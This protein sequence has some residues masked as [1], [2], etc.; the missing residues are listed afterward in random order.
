MMSAFRDT[1]ASRW[2]SFV[3]LP[4]EGNN[5]PR[6]RLLAHPVQRWDGHGG[7]SVQRSRSYSGAVLAGAS[8]SRATQLLGVQRTCL[9]R[10]A[11]GPLEAVGLTPRRRA[12]LALR[13]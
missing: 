4:D 3:L 5:A 12:S 2:R 10:P 7:G 9:G 11:R 6:P 1:N 8:Q 13:P